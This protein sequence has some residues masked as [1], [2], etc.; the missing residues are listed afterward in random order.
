VRALTKADPS[1]DVGR[2]G[3]GKALRLHALAANGHPVPAWAVIGIDVFEHFMQTIGWRDE[4]NRALSGPHLDASLDLSAHILQADV[5]DGIA[6]VIAEAYDLAGGGD[7]AVRS[8]GVEEDALT[9]SF[10]GQFDSFLNIRGIEQVVLHVK[11]CWASTFSKRAVLYRQQHGLV[12]HTAAMAVIVQRLIRAEKSGVLFTVNPSNGS[13]R[14]LV[15]SSTYGLG[16]TLV[17]G[18]V[19]ADTIIVDRVSGEPCEVCVGEKHERLVPSDNGPGC[20]ALDLS[21]EQRSTL[22]LTDEEISDLS[23]IGCDI[24]DAFGV[25][26]D[27]EWAFE[28]G[29]LWILQSRPVTTVAAP[30][31]EA[32]ENRLVGQAS[33]KGRLRIWDNSNIIESYGDITS[34]LTFTFARHAYHQV[35]RWYCK[36]LGVPERLLRDMDEWQANRLAHFNGRVYYNLLNWYRMQHLLPFAGMKRRMME[37]AMGVDEELSDEIAKEIR[38]FPRRSRATERLVRFIVSTV[39]VRRFVRSRRE[40]KRFVDGFDKKFGV[41]DETDYGSM[42]AEELYEQMLMLDREL[43]PTWGPMVALEAIILTALGLLF[44]LTRLWLPDAPQWLYWNVGKP[45][46][47][48]ASAEPARRMAELAE[49]VA[50]DPQLESSV[51]ELDPREVYQQLVAIGKKDFL[52]AVDDYVARFGYRC[53]NELKLEEPSMR[54]DITVFFKLLRGMQPK[55]TSHAPDGQRGLLAED[56]DPDAYLALHMGR[57][58]RLVYEAVRRKAQAALAAREQVRLCRS[59]AF[60]LAR[61]IFRALDQELIRMGVLEN[62]G[63]IFQLRLEEL[64]ACF[65]GTMSPAEI[66]PVVALRKQQQVAHERLTAPARFVTRGPMY[67]GGNLERAGWYG[68]VVREGRS[69]DSIS[70]EGNGERRLRG[71][72]CCSGRVEG[73]AKVLDAP[74]DVNGAVIVAYRTD[75]GWIAALPSA[76]ALL[77]ERGS[78][79]THVAIVARELNIPTVVQ[80]KDLTSEV[81]TGMR[82]AVDGSDGIVTILAEKSS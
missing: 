71:I 25:P 53:A 44:G 70:V 79:L 59:R 51:R 67:W 46:K 40:V 10:A 19:D 6:H 31:V 47:G 23:R 34:P 24:E 62:A 80:I 74:V 69:T 60:G 27:I 65:E 20:I 22:S 76:S 54:D 81:Q 4:V 13:H 18:A 16:E 56:D 41:L 38:P 82:L 2:K 3:G 11:R 49:M 8:S 15:I 29:V 55:P 73:D 48:V 77:V 30:A 61:R 45:R 5:E 33:Q 68:G 43:L 75:P 35:Y 66:A 63:D 57:M 9:H 1:V 21:V 14:E 7:V 52:M 17:E 78:P 12:S 64:R 37:V 36:S 50:A 58:K 39:F 28:E 42:S 32:G 26:Q 72:G